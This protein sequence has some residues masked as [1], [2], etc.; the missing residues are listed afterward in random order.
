MIRKYSDTLLIFK[1]KQID[2]SYRETSRHEITGAEGADL[3]FT[4]NIGGT[5]D[6]GDS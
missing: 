6:D 5:S 2:P 4:L 3:T 1:V